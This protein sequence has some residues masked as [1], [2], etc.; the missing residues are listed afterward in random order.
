[1]TRYQTDILQLQCSHSHYQ[2]HRKEQIHQRPTAHE[3]V[4]LVMRG[5]SGHMTKMAV[6]P[7]DPLCFTEPELLPTEVLLSFFAGIRIFHLCCSWQIEMAENRDYSYKEWVFSR[8][9][10]RIAAFW[11]K[12]DAAK[13]L[14][15]QWQII[16]W[17]DRYTYM[18]TDKQ[19]DTQDRNYIPCHFLGS[20]MWT[21]NSSRTAGHTFCV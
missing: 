3:Y 14:Q 11:K 9:N 10:D 2:L 17:Q 15:I 18:H 19:T 6:T 21:A 4:H 12:A 1:M 16:Q 20:N 7:F 5:H 8:I 13:N